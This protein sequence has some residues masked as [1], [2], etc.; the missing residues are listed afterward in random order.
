[1]N[2][3]GYGHTIHHYYHDSNP[4]G[5]GRWYGALL[6]FFLALDTTSQTGSYREGGEKNEK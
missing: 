2:A 5:V 1:M 4:T 6:A 3:G